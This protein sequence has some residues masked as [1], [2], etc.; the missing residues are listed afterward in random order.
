MFWKY[1]TIN[2]KIKT[3]FIS[4]TLESVLAELLQKSQNNIKSLYY[5]QEGT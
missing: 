5:H 4:I 1:N 2:K 3:H